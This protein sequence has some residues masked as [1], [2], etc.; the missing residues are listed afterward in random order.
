[1]EFKESILDKHFSMNGNINLAPLNIDHLI[2][3]YPLFM[4]FAAKNLV[5]ESKTSNQFWNFMVTEIV[6][7]WGGKGIGW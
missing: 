3:F 6:L 2:F 7:D 4:G 5:W 1:M